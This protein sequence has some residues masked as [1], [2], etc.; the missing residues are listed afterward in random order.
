[1]RKILRLLLT[2]IFAFQL[3]TAF[4]AAELGYPEDWQAWTSMSTALT[5]IG[6]L[7]GC[8]ADVSSLPGIYQATVEAYCAVRPQGPGA[9]AVLVR[10]SSVANYKTR[11]GRLGEGANMIL[12]LKELGILMVTGHKN[13]QAMYGVFKE[14]GT[15][16]TDANPEAILGAQFCRACHT[17]YKAFCVNGQCGAAR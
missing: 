1:M 2:A 17:G 9:V 10:P 7:P 5:E 8:D 15:D 6:A 12:H 13:G 4:A 16:V 3:N 11:N 14:D